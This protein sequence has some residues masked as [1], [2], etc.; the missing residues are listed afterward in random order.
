MADTGWLSFGTYTEY[1]RSGSD[2]GS[3]TNLTNATSEDG[4][5]TYYNVTKDEY[6][7]YIAGSNI[8]SLSIASGSTID[9]IEFKFKRK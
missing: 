9:G 3:W 4:N 1:A 6:S 7:D 5:T 2:A 8:S